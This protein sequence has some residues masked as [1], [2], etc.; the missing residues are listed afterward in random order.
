M[1]DHN[2]T[3][4]KPPKDPKTSG[5][6][7]NGGFHHKKKVLKQT[8]KPKLTNQTKKP[9]L[10]DQGRCY[11]FGTITGKPYLQLEILLM[12]KVSYIYLNFCG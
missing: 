5:S 10:L 12:H 6:H 1:W 8:S 2:I 9:T 4:K 11:E 7:K 3:F